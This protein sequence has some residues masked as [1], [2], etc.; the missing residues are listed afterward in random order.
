MFVENLLIFK[1]SNQVQVAD[2]SLLHLFGDESDLAS[3]QY[4]LC[5]P[6]VRTKKWKRGTL[7]HPAKGFALYTPIFV[8]RSV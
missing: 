1:R 7:S 3:S 8:L 4:S 5:G 2:R 6:T